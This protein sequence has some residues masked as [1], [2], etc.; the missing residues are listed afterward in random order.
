MGPRA[1]SFKN[2][3]KIKGIEVYRIVDETWEVKAFSYMPSFTNYSGAIL[4]LL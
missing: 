4:L 1:T 2:K 3:N